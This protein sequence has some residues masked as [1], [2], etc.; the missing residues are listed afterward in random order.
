[1]G[2]QESFTLINTLIKCIATV[3]LDSIRVTSAWSSEEF[4][5]GQASSA[6]SPAFL[7][8]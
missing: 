5:T 6:P 1:M 4:T 8:R 7:P 2:V 3:G